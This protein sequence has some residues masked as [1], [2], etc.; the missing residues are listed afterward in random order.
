MS[1]GGYSRDPRAYGL[2]IEEW[3]QCAKG[4][5][6]L[7][8]IDRVNTPPKGEKWCEADFVYD[9]MRKDP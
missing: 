7:A 4:R 6:L 8:E 3:D 1:R 2:P 5:D 9:P